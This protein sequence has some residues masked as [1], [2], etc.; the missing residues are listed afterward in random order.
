MAIRTI[1]TSPAVFAGG[2]GRIIH[3]LQ[4]TAAIGATH[5][6]S[7]QERILT[8]ETG[9]GDADA[10]V[11]YTHPRG[12]SVWSRIN[13]TTISLDLTA[14]GGAGLTHNY[15]NAEISDLFLQVGALTFNTGADA[16]TSAAVVNNGAQ[17]NLTFATNA[18]SLQVTTAGNDNSNTTIVR[19]T[20]A[21]GTTVH[22]LSNAPITDTISVWSETQRALLS[23]TTGGTN[24]TVVTITGLNSGAPYEIRYRYLGTASTI[25]NVNNLRNIDI[26]RN[27]NV[28]WTAD[29]IGG[30]IVDS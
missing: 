14:G 12:S 26:P 5:L 2:G 6:L 24:D 11:D 27:H 7:L 4:G 17:L 8:T 28:S 13:T 23:F 19:F 15:T 9:S 16:P 20:A 25:G 3:P 18:A 1:T 21:A 30:L 29:N 22:T 10:V